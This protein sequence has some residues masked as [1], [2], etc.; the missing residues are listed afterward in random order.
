MNMPL[1]RLAALL[2]APLLGAVLGWVLG[3]FWRVPVWAA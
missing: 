3:S 2:L 1:G